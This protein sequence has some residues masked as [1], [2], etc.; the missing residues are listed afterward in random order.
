MDEILEIK[1]QNDELRE[2]N[3][4]LKEQLKIKDSL[5]F[6]NDSYYLADKEKKYKR[7]PILFKLL[8]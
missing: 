1:K 2:E 8:R 4:I 3:P 5:L 6:K 7:W